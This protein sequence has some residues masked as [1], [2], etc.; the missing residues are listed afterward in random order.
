[1]LACQPSPWRRRRD[2]SAVYQ[3]LYVEVLESRTLPSANTWPGLTNPVTH[4]GANATLDQA[5]NLGDL[6]TLG[7]GAA[8][9]TITNPATG[10]GDIQWYSFTLDSPASVRIETLDQG[11][12]TFVSLLSLYNSDPG[13]SADFYDP[14]GHRL[15]AQNDGAS[16]GG[17]AQIGTLLVAGTYYVG[18]SGSGNRYFSPVIADS[19]YSASA[20]QYGLLLTATSLRL[21]PNAGPFV[22]AANPASGSAQPIS[23]FVLRVDFSSA[24]APSSIQPGQDVQLIWNANG[25]FGDGSDRTVPLAGSNFSAALDELQL[26][27]AAPLAPGYYRLILNGNESA[28]VPVLTDTAGRFLGQ[29][30]L[31]P[32]GQNYTIAFHI[33]GSEGIAGSVASADDTAPT[34]YQL[35]NITGAG[36][37]QLAGAI[38]VDP[39]D[40]IPF[41]P[42]SVNLY[43]FQISG[44]GNYSFQSEVFAGRIGSPLLTALSLFRYDPVSQQLLLVDAD[45]GSENDTQVSFNNSF[46]LETDSV[47]DGGL[48]AG[49]YYI[50]VS[51]DGNVPVPEQGALPGMDGIFD[52]NISHSGQG[53]DSTGNYVLNL[54]VR[55]DNVAPK[56]TSITLTDGT[57]LKAGTTLN[58]PLTGFTVQFSE[59][60]DIPQL[61]LD[62]FIETSENALG[63][64]FIVGPS[65]ITYPHFKGYDIQGNFESYNSQGNS[66]TFVM[67]DALP[68]GS[69]ELHFSAQADLPD[70]LGNPSTIVGLTDLAGNALPANDPSGDYVI[71]FTVTGPAR[72]TG[73]NPQA[74]TAQEPNGG[75]T[76]PQ[77]IGPLFPDELGSQAQVT[78]T[79]APTTTPNQNADYYQIQLLETKDYYFIVTG[80][81][82]PAGLQISVQGPTDLSTT[83]SQLQ[84]VLASGTY[85]VVVSWASGASNVGYQLAISLITAPEPPPP[86][87]LGPGPG[88]RFQFVANVLPPVGNPGGG[89]PANPPPPSSP[90]PGG[91]AG[92][93]SGSG[94]TGSPPGLE[95][96]GYPIVSTII[97]STVGSR[98]GSN[99]PALGGAGSSSSSSQEFVPFSVLLALGSGPLSGISTSPVSDATVASD[100]YDRVLAQGPGLSFTAIATR[101]SV[102]TQLPESGSSQGSGVPSEFAALIESMMRALSNVSWRGAVEFLHRELEPDDGAR[103][104]EIDDRSDPEPDSSQEQVDVELSA[105][106]QDQPNDSWFDESLGTRALAVAAAFALVTPRIDPKERRA[107]ARRIN[108]QKLRDA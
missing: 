3:R 9:G 95:T 54:M 66:V 18:V 85:T 89:S 108:A 82:L 87:T 71:P 5:I 12:T 41:D 79:R 24:L 26:T 73:G 52:P 96:T 56:I 30:T 6:T 29:S 81:N 72:G 17:D 61:A 20:G 67:Y 76:N 98:T 84:A 88:I 106:L 59:P 33:T 32:Q 60:M 4:T 63:Q 15:L 51:S 45:D 50:A 101:L 105:C 10:G 11:H 16:N 103:A 14:T 90:P 43:H 35:G 1:V 37:V 57:A 78:V 97:V 22:L 75:P 80:A 27:P 62:S 8:I 77:V 31:S 94:S 42:S 13:D 100:V 83:G 49:D 91:N 39:T 21:A 46:P 23:P 19:G 28:G 93:S 40:P 48:T 107:V 64:V 36:L 25:T 104:P 102:L 86:L 58:G 2:R 65:G 7:S 68:N 70:V 34:A 38:G 74:W 69:Y 55:S 47:L 53:G 92:G 99:L 44:S